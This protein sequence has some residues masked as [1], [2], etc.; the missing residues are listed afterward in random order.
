MKTTIYNTKYY[1]YSLIH[2]WENIGKHL[3]ISCASIFNTIPKRN[4]IERQNESERE[5]EFLLKYPSRYLFILSVLFWSDWFGRVVNSFL[6]I[7][8]IKRFNRS[9]QNL[10]N[11]RSIFLLLPVKPH[12]K[13]TLFSEIFK[14]YFVRR[15]KNSKKKSNSKLYSTSSVTY[16]WTKG[17]EAC[18]NSWWLR[19]GHVALIVRAEE[20]LN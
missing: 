4:E 3:C 19:L 20:E 18:H 13:A 9:T 6:V 14:I 17:K 10:S 7:F 8:R 5:R 16:Q 11:K 12:Q 1:V 15:I 2:S